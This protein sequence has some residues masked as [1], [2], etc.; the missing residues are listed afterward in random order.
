MS[1][2]CIS[3]VFDGQCIIPWTINSIETGQTFLGL[4][5]QIRA[6]SFQES[7]SKL[8]SYP[9]HLWVRIKTIWLLLLASY[10]WMKYASSLVHMSDWMFSKIASTNWKPSNQQR[11]A[12]LPWT[13][14]DGGRTLGKN[15]ISCLCNALWYIDGQP[16]KH[17]VDQYQPCLRNLMDTMFL[18]G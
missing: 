15:I 14:R 4:Y 6:E 2:L 7:A 17:V 5:Q 8:K 11:Q 10:P 3:V 1:I 9:K 16:W 12:H 13:W 18:N